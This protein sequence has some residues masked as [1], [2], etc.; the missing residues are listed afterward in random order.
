VSEPK[1]GIRRLFHFEALKGLTLSARWGFSVDFVPLLSGRKLVWKKTIRSATFDLCF[2][3]IDK[4]GRVPDWCSFARDASPASIAKTARTA[5]DMAAKD[6]ARVDTVAD[7]CTLFDERSRIKFARFSLSNY[8]Q[9]DLAWGL[10]L[11][12]CGEEAR[13]EEHISKF[14]RA[15]D[16]DPDTRLVRMSAAEARTYRQ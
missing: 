8:V 1:A 13:G 15:F 14:C 9:T 10:A 11:L 12:A 7:I 4:E 3:P 2:D 6:F 5:F 16:I